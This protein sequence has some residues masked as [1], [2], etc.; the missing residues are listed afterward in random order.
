M[1]DFGMAVM[2]ISEARAALPAVLTRVA[3]GEEITITRHGSPV[4]V[5]VRPDVVWSQPGT[6]G[7]VDET[8]V[9]VRILRERARRHG[10]SLEQELRA[11]VEVASKDPGPATLPPI[12]LAT[13]R[14]ATGSTWSREEIYGDEGR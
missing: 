6:E 13:V 3:Q 10:R 5:V 8:E 11:I 4:A 1:Y 14:R 9:L 12:R 7:A 2:T